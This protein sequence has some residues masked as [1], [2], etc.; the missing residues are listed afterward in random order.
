MYLQKSLRQTRA[1]VFLMGLSLIPGCATHRLQTDVDKIPS[2]ALP[3]AETGR[4][5]EISQKLNSTAGADESEFMLLPDN[6]NSLRWRVLLA[7][8]AEQS[9]DLQYYLIDRDDSSRYF[10]MALVRAANRGVR[11]RLLVDDVFLMNRDDR[12]AAWSEHPH[13]EIRVFNPWHKRGSLVQ[14]GLE[15]LG[16][17]ERLNQRMHNKLFAVDNRIAIIGG[18]N[19]GDAYFGLSDKYNFR[20]LDVIVAGPMVDKVS[21]SFDLY[22]N[23]E[24]TVSAAAFARPDREAPLKE[25]MVREGA[26]L[27]AA[28]DKAGKAGLLKPIPSKDFL[29]HLLSNSVYGQAWAVYD[30]PPSEIANQQGV[31]KIDQLEDIDSAIERELLI[32]S[33]YLVPSEIFMDKLQQMSQRGVRVRLLTNSLA[34]TNHTMVHSG[35]RPWRRR[36]IDAGIELYEYRADASD[37]AG[38]LA[39]GMEGGFTSLHTKT[40]VIDREFVYLGSLNMDPRSFHI[41]TEMGLLVASPQ[42]A[43]QVAVLLEREIAPENAWRVTR[44][45]EG[46]LAWTSSAGTSHLQPARGFAQRIADFFYGLLPI[47]DQL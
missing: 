37:T 1:L 39:A 26:A 14:R 2:Q 8:L 21:D 18:R 32:A 27:L 16:Y 42:L 35:Y 36:L 6:L 11:V 9:I 3:P 43:D 28:S 17:S 20:D 7:D 5:H 41:N 23:D 4:I 29:D 13:I 25:H 30:D 40:F 12:I 46:R 19:I 44:D 47:K 22:W 15:Y 10:A 45:D 34:S 24:W 33:P 38:V 31:R